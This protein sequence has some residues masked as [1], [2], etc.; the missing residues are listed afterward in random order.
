[1]GN[2]I[3]SNEKNIRSINNKFQEYI[4]NIYLKIDTKKKVFN[5][6]IKY[7]VI[8]ENHNLN[9]LKYLILTNNNDKNIIEYV[10]KADVYSLQ[11]CVWTIPIYKVNK[12]D[13][14]DLCY[15][16]KNDETKISDD[17]Y[18]IIL[19]NPKLT[20]R[21]GEKI[22]MLKLYIENNELQIGE[23]EIGDYKNVIVSINK[24]TIKKN[25]FI[26]DNFIIT[27][28]TIIK[29]GVEFDLNMLT[30]E[31]YDK[32]Y[33]R[34]YYEKHKNSVIF[35]LIKNDIDPKNIQYKIV[36][37]IYKD[38]NSRG[39]YL[40]SDMF[41]VEGSPLGKF[42][43]TFVVNDDK[44]IILGYVCKSFDENITM[45]KFTDHIYYC[46]YKTNEAEN[47]VLML[48]LDEKTRS[49]IDMI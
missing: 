5:F 39:I 7:I 49:S 11:Y 28:K 22:E 48:C 20:N 26:N 2:N 3:S 42:E 8:N 38:K 24:K 17:N 37:Y 10:F 14:N 29:R 30:R 6:S 16:N 13:N 21:N 40:A 31:K 23:F 33:S 47:D 25:N 45:R 15:Y 44:G 35:T 18:D 43:I 36:S 4:K 27:N 34:K 41:A 32:L 19:E 46:E 1:M 12:N 9:C